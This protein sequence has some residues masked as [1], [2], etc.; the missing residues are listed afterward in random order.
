M[1]EN[2]SGLARWQ[3]HCL[4]AHFNLGGTLRLNKGFFL[5]T[6]YSPAALKFDKMW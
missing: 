5:E 6:K 4:H 3:T 1:A 2:N